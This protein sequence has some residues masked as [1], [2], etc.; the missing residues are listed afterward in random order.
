MTT[1]IPL[2]LGIIFGLLI[3]CI[4]AVLI[5]DKPDDMVKKPMLDAELTPAQAIHKLQEIKPY[6]AYKGRT[7]TAIDMAIRALQEGNDESEGDL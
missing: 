3:A 2:A 1:L 4:V 5:A 6:Y 7:W